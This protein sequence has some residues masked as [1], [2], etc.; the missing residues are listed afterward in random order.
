[1]VSY[2]CSGVTMAERNLVD[3]IAAE[4]RRFMWIE[5]VPV[6]AEAVAALFEPVHLY[7]LRAETGYRLKGSDLP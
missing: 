4:L 6:V 5:S 1:M 3:C 7:G 2:C